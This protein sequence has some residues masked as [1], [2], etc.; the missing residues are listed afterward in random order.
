MHLLKITRAPTN[1]KS[2]YSCHLPANPVLWESETLY[3]VKI[4]PLWKKS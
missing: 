4:F 2:S 1:T 3:A